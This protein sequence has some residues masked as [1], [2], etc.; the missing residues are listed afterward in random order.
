MAVSFGRHIQMPQTTNWGQLVAGPQIE[1]NK[2]FQDTVPGVSH[3][4]PS[5][6]LVLFFL[7]ASPEEFLKSNLFF[8]QSL[9]KM[10]AIA[11]PL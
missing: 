10:L 3:S 9:A 7:R 5:K 6:R 1:K 8:Y 4:V 2:L 11:L